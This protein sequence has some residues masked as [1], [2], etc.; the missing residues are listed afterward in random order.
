MVWREPS[1]S[2]PSPPEIFPLISIDLLLVV[3]P[4]RTAVWVFELCVSVVGSEGGR[5]GGCVLVDVPTCL[6]GARILKLAL[7]QLTTTVNGSR[8]VLFPPPWPLPS[9]YFYL[10]AHP[11]SFLPKDLPRLLVHQ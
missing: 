7:A 5:E 2:S 3:R 6:R 8:C 4:E 9:L 10:L 1:P 11:F